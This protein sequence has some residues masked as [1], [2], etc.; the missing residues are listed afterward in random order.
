MTE[1]ILI[2]GGGFVGLNLAYA[3]KEKGWDPYISDCVQR[4]HPPAINWLISDIT[5]EIDVRNIV[6]KIKP[7]YIVNVAALADIDKAEQNK[8]LAYKINVDGAKYL[9]EASKKI[10]ARYIYFSSDAVFSGKD[11]IYYDDDQAAPV[12]YYGYTKSLAEK[13]VLKIYPES[14]ILRVSLILGYSIAGGNSFFESFR[15]N[16]KIMTVLPVQFQKSGHRLMFI[17]YVIVLLCF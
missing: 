16:W 13:E 14:V 1:K 12:N 10:K 6:E 3:A 2:F 4:P 15:K 7:E 17:L 8:E 9:A 11:S 5:D